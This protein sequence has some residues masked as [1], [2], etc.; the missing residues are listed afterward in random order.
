LRVKDIDF[1]RHDVIL[2]EADGV[3][4]AA[5]LLRRWVAIYQAAA[6]SAA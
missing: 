3:R 2:D 1:E 4:F 6:G 5:E